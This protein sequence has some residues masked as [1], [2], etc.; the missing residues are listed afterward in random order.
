MK[1]ILNTTLDKF[2]DGKIHLHQPDQGFR[3]GS[4]SVFVAS[5]VPAL[6]GDKI[7]E[8]GAGAGAALLCLAARVPGAK[9]TGLE[10]QRNM[11]R[12]CAQNIQHNK[13]QDRV[14]ILSGNL[15]EPPPR[16]AASSFSHVFANPPYFEEK[17]STP[18]PIETKALSH[19]DG[20]VSLDAWVSFCC[21]MVRPK[22]SVTFIF[23][24]PRLDDLIAACHG[25]LGG[26][27]VY[28]LWPKPGQP[29]K[30]VIVQGRKN[31][32]GPMIL[33]PGLMLHGESGAYTAEAQGIL[34][35]GNALKLT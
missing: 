27:I 28:P 35:A 29:S 10:M 3:A 2:L 21:R 1:T 9:V 24:T 17:G 11:V 26:I 25:K 30:R 7:L 23:P 6:A 22:G 4:D 13:M 5:A 34:R 18:S 8:V 12:L 32:Q 16:L 20:N 14:E 19:M 31:S 33:H 15:L